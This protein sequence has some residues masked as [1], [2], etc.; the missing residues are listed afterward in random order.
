MHLVNGAGNSPSLGRLTPGVVKQDKSSGGSVDQCNIS[1][2]RVV[3]AA[4]EAPGSADRGPTVHPPY[5]FS[6]L[7]VAASPAWIHIP[8]PPPPFVISPP[9]L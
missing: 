4:F 3:C 6:L 1:G 5:C 7:H 2:S 9:M 8:Y